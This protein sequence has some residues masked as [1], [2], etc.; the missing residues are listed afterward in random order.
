MF[1]CF[2]CI[3][4]LCDSLRNKKDPG[5]LGLSG[6]KKKNADAMVVLPFLLFFMFE[7]SKHGGTFNL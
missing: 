5:G 7:H 6:E 1:E 2:L 4:C 3:L